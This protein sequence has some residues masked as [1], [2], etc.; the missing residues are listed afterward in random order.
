MKTYKD[1]VS[2]T[3]TL[4]ALSQPRPG[5]SGAA[6]I[7]RPTSL[8]GSG[9]PFQTL[10]LGELRDHQY[11]LYT[12]YCGGLK[13]LRRLT[14]LY[15]QLDGGVRAERLTESR[16]AF[17]DLQLE[18]YLL[19]QEL[20]R[21]KVVKPERLK[22]VNLTLTGGLHLI[23]AGRWPGELVTLADFF[24]YARI[25]Q[26]LDSGAVHVRTTKRQQ[27]LKHL[28]LPWLGRYL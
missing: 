9:S 23:H 8:N 20:I 11:D 1:G 17:D 22:L 24:Y 27:L 6:P 10:S 13:E 15:C 18:L 14:D 7:P 25:S 4:P 26:R 21:R 19:E 2:Q 12:A 28:R 16:T 5:A 3:R